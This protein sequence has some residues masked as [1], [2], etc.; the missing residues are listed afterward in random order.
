MAARSSKSSRVALLV[1]T[2]KGAWVFTSDAARKKWSA[3]GPFR[4][5]EIVYHFLL[6]PRDGRT[7]VMALKAGHLGPTVVRSTDRGKT[8]TEAKAPPAF[9]KGEPQGRSVSHVFWLTPGHASRPGE[10]F[11]GTA[12]HGMFRSRDGG[13]TWE[14]LK[15]FNDH[16]NWKKWRGD[17]DPP[18]APNTHSILVDP[19]DADHLYVGM[20]AGGVLESRDGGATWKPMNEGL[21]SDFKPKDGSE[22]YGFDPHC[23]Q[24]HPQKP[25]RLYQQ[26][27]WGIYRIDRPSDTWVRIGRKMPKE[28]GDIGFPMVLHPRDPETCWVF[29]MDGTSVWPRT[30]VGGKPAA[31]RTRDGGGKWERQDKGF[32][33]SQAWWTV[34]RQ[35]MCADD[36]DPVGLYL[37]TT[38]GEVWWSP[39]EGR[40]WRNLARHLPHIYCVTAARI[41]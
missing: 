6:D 39:D 23:M 9:P 24:I 17:I 7:M 35:A 4:F 28:I 5:G 14:S 20:S 22:F 37:G 40:S 16:P 2:R 13:A 11:A 38:N 3:E 36:R 19:R 33:R 10:W 25:D 15:G 27:H 34:K 29:P 12:P 32:P 41:G 18:D 1:G 26:N 31:Y 8:W 30:S 21:E